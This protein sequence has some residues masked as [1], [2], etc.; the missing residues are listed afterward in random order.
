MADNWTQFSE[1]I[2]R[3]TLEE[4]T[5]IHQQLDSEAKADEARRSQLAWQPEDE[6]DEVVNFEWS[7]KDDRDE[8]D[9]WGRHLWLHSDEGSN[10]RDVARF[11]QAF[12]KKFRPDQCFSLT[13]ADTCSK[14]RVGEFSGGAMFVT[15][16]GVEV[17]SPCEWSS[18]RQR[19]FC[20]ERPA[21]KRLIAQAETASID[22]SELDE[23][24]HDSKAAEAAAINN[25][26]LDDQITFLAASLGHQIAQ[27]RIEEI[28]LNHA[29]K[30][31]M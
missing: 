21:I 4:E 24:V 26:G 3:L 29:H 22:P 30:E 6:A 1:V 14:S 12:L 13:W 27:E 28:V 15:A 20:E 25:G 11:I 5:W 18:E 23:L 19:W 10:P 9:G 17:C 8:P 2:P 16:H 31:I 7:I